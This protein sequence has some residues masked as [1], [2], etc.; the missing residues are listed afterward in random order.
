MQSSSVKADLSGRDIPML[1]IY[2]QGIF[3]IT[4]VIYPN[5]NLKQ[6]RRAEVRRD[7]EII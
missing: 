6:Q 2:I 3:N 5:F 1:H 4:M 7:F